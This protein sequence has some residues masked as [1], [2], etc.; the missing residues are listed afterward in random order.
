M[1]V[2]LIQTTDVALV[3]AAL[4]FLSLVIEN[5]CTDPEFAIPLRFVLES[6]GGETFS[7]SQAALRFV[8]TVIGTLGWSHLPDDAFRVYMTGVVDLM[9]SEIPRE[10]IWF[11]DGLLSALRE[12]APGFSDYV[13]CICGELDIWDVLGEIS[14]E[15]ITVQHLCMKIDQER[16]ILPEV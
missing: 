8:Y 3:E 4:N 13:A 16:G 14:Q 15:N 2:G 12:E 10:C 11:L 6:I 1:L 7:M 9:P 5:R